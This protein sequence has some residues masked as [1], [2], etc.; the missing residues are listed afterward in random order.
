[1]NVESVG[2][3]VDV[4]SEVVETEVDRGEDE[5]L[6]RMAMQVVRFWII[7]RMSRCY[8][9]ERYSDSLALPIGR[10]WQR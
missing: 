4:S 9:R 5:W 3:D 8:V 7:L 10:A 6:R 2:D 1:M